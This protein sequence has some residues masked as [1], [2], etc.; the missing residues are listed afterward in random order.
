[1]QN[2]HIN[3][4]KKFAWFFHDYLYKISL[5][6]LI[7]K[8]IWYFLMYTASLY[9]TFIQIASVSHLKGKKKKHKKCTIGSYYC[10]FFGGGGWISVIDKAKMQIFSLDFKI[11]LRIGRFFQ[12]DKFPDC[13]LIFGIC[14]NT[15]KHQFYSFII[16]YLFI[17]YFIF[18]C[19]K[20]QFKLRINNKCDKIA[21][22]FFDFS[23][24]NIL[25]AL[26][27]IFTKN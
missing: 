17:F 9:N 15:F 23:L 21:K 26:F 24:N 18:F 16:Y 12:I 6:S 4:E 20:W 25:L 10:L 19:E 5:I 2:G 8:Q 14:S 11:F 7:N 27:S 1:M 3:F 22:I 13:F